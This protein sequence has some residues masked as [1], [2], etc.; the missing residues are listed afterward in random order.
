[1]KENRN[2]QIEGRAYSLLH[3][4]FLEGYFFSAYKRQHIWSPGS[5][6]LCR[7]DPQNLWEKLPVPASTPWP[8]LAMVYWRRKKSST[9]QDVPSDR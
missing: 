2:I 8:S 9:A 3:K 7:N 1:M 6:F 5:S 4:R